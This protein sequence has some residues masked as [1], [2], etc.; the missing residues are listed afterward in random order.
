[1]ADNFF[2]ISLK[3]A[4]QKTISLVHYEEFTIIKKV[5]EF[6]SQLFET[7][8]GTHDHLNILVFDFSKVLLDHRTTNKVT[9]IAFRK[10]TQFLS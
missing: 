7:T 2:N 3:V 8:W 5:I 1:M 4:F 6:F 9:N 10:F